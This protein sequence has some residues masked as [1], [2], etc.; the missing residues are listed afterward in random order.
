MWKAKRRSCYQRFVDVASCGWCE[1]FMRRHW[2]FFSRKTTIAQKDPFYTVDC[3]L[4][5]VMQVYRIEKQFNFH[6]AEIIA[7][8]ETPV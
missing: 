4:A 1:E 3:I 7:I 8:D 2:F 6:D 5:Y